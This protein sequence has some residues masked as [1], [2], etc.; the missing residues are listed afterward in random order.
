MNNKFFLAQDEKRIQAAVHAAELKTS[1][2][3]VPVIASR[4]VRY[5]WFAALFGFFG[6]I[7]GTASYFLLQHFFPF[8]AEH[9]FVFL[10]QGGGLVFGLLVGCS[11]WVMRMVLGQA[12][13]TEEV[14]AAAQ[15]AFVQEG[16][17]NTQDRT[18]ILIYIALQEHRVVVLGDRGINEKVST[19]YWEEAGKK[20]VAGIRNGTAGDALVEVIE[21]MGGRLAE[22]FPRKAN[23]TNEL[24]DKPRFR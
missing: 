7:A 14:M 8:A 13:L 4:S 22:H 18:G 16:L 21:E 17:I 6:L 2:E 19:T 1:G 12:R 5:G 3:I 15:L 11:S 23:D 10:L 24:G 9:N 20:I